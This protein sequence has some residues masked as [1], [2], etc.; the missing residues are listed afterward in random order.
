M[1]SNISLEI[2]KFSL[3]TLHKALNG[4]QRGLWAWAG[5][6]GLESLPE[7]PWAAS[8]HSP[9]IDYLGRCCCVRWALLTLVNWSGPRIDA[10]LSPLILT[11]IVSLV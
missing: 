6:M 11:K 8:A 3:L 4:T 10:G 9:F 5:P 1:K 7:A 2:A